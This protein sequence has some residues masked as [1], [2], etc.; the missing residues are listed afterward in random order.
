MLVLVFC[1]VFGASRVSRMKFALSRWMPFLRM[2]MV[3]DIV[4]AVA[5]Y[6]CKT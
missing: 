6:V 3:L 5:V 1:F 2:S 4:F